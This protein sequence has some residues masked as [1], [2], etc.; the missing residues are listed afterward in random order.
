[1]PTARDVADCFLAIATANADDGEVLTHLKLQK[2]L[3]I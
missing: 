3:G 2:L 1:M